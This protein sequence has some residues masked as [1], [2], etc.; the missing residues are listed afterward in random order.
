MIRRPPRSTRTDT[1]FPYTTLFRSTLNSFDHQRD[2][3]AHTNAHGAQRI[4]ALDPVQL[5]DGGGDQPRAARA[6]RMTQR[7]RAT[8]GIDAWIC[9]IQSEPPQHREALRGERFVEFDDEIG[10]AHV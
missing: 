1:L 6:Q 7:N 8:V 5:V 2:A 10:R 3:L 9:I 4:A